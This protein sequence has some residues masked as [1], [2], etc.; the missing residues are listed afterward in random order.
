MGWLRGGWG[1]AYPSGKTCLPSR[2]IEILCWGLLILLF[3]ILKSMLINFQHTKTFNKVIP[4][5]N[6][7]TNTYK[8]KRCYYFHMIRVT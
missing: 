1:P 4:P 5:A 6:V 8:I 7:I 2:N 3:K